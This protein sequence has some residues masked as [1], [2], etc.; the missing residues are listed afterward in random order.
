MLCCLPPIFFR[1][2]HVLVIGLCCCLPIRGNEND[3]LEGVSV[4]KEY[5]GRRLEPRGPYVLHGIGQTTDA[6]REYTAQMGEN[7]P[8]VI[9]WYWLGKTHRDTLDA[10]MEK[11]GIYLIPQI[12]IQ[13]KDR[14]DKIAAGE[15]E[16]FN[17][18]FYDRLEAFDHP[19]FLRIGFEFNG[20]WNGYDP[21]TYRKAWIHIAKRIRERKSLENVA[22]VWCYAEEGMDQDYME[23]YPGDEWVDWWGIDLF[24]PEHLYSGGTKKFLEDAAARRYPV[25]IGESTP[26]WVQAIE[27]ERSWDAWFARYFRLIKRNPHIK[28]FCYIT[29]DWAK[30]YKPGSTL[31]E[32]GDARV[33]KDSLVF[34]RWREELK[35]PRYIHGDDP[36][37]VKMLLGITDDPKPAKTDTSTSS[38]RSRNEPAMR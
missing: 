9:M 21:E 5:F 22:L 4:S 33:W 36:K 20:E 27:G 25:M 28:S 2:I 37:R 29:Y 18:G 12:G 10:L 26:R 34:A 6:F 1:R 13:M 19:I 32:W 23:Y 15:H 38:E 8:A 17:K 31:H 3:E 11:T 30:H 24:S 7:K 35:K 16:W 14:A